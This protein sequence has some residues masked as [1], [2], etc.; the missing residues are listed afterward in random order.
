M[1]GHGDDLR[2]C[3]HHNLH[4]LSRRAVLQ[5]VLNDVVAVLIL[6]QLAGGLR[7]REKRDIEQS[8]RSSFGQTPGGSP[9][10][11]ALPRPHPP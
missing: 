9:Q 10:P 2:R 4:P 1:H 7:G 11:N 6:G 8:D 5:H 3:L